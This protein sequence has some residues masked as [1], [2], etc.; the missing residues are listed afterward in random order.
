MS[1]P[2]GKKDKKSI[3]GRVYSAGLNFKNKT[4]LGDGPRTTGVITVPKC[5]T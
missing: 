1:S 5:E 4:Y 2:L 3:L